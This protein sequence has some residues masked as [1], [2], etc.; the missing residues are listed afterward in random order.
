MSL[1]PKFWPSSQS[2]PI[3]E[4]AE[5]GRRLRARKQAILAC[6][7]TAGPASGA[8]EAPNGL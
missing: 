8:T 1:S 6:F 2:C 4:V 7:D 3:P 5:P